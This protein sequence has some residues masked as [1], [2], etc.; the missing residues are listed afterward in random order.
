MTFVDLEEEEGSRLSISSE[1]EEHQFDNWNLTHS[2]PFRPLP[3][4]DTPIDTPPETPPESPTTVPIYHVP[5]PRAPPPPIPYFPLPVLNPPSGNKTLTEKYRT[6]YKL[7]LIGDWETARDK[8]FNID[9]ESITAGITMFSETALH[10]AAKAGHENFAVELVKLMPPRALVHQEYNN[11]DTPLHRAAINGITKAA[12]AIVAKNPVVVQIRNKK[13]WIPLLSAIYG[14]SYQQREM[15][16]FLLSAHPR[17][18]NRSPFSG[19]IGGELICT[20]IRAGFFDIAT[21]LIDDHPNL[22]VEKDK[23]DSCALEVLAEMRYAFPSGSRLVSWQRYVYSHITVVLPETRQ[24]HDTE[25]PPAS[26]RNIST[27]S[28]TTKLLSI[29]QLTT[30]LG[31]MKELLRKVPCIKKMYDQKLMHREALELVRCIYAQISKSDSEISEF[32]KDTSIFM[33][34]TTYGTVEIIVECIERFPD[35]I[36]LKMKGRNIFEIA[37]EERHEKIFNLVHKM[38]ESKK[39]L[40]HLRDDFG[41]NILHIAALL[42]SPSCRLQPIYCEALQMQIELQWFKEVERIALPIH[43][44]LRNKDGKTPLALFTEQHKEL[45]EK[46]EKWMKGTTESCMLV[47]TLIATVVFAAAFTVPGGNFSDSARGENG[48]PILLYNN[49]FMVF[50]VADALALFSSTTSVLVFLAILNSRYAAEDF[51]KSLPQKLIIGLATLVISIATMMIAFCATLYIALA[52]RF[53]WT[54]IFPL[55]AL[56]SAPVMSFVA[57]Q[58]PL[59]LD[60]CYTTYGRNIFGR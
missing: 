8:F 47:A 7:A 20:L 11:G 57:L 18:K 29:T 31:W 55:V 24:H 4:P 37:I 51:H 16:E 12:K 44:L 14:S 41:N 52:P 50:V 30:V 15:I 10:I 34:A 13:G 42:S 40:V 1:S 54:L 21:K 5:P 58:L 3:I 25:N 48:I 19:R 17:H 22:A 59:F 46:A 33:V 53:G 39:E 32:F 56:A 28:P 2:D 27:A 35:M 26:S 49:S 45:M 38:N 23:D 6:L 9:S 60:L 36:W 43:K